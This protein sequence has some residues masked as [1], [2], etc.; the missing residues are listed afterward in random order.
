MLKQTRLEQI[1]KL[2]NSNGSVE[3]NQLCRLFGVT[4]M[5]ARRDLDELAKAGRVIRTHGGAVLSE[6]NIL[7]EKPF[8][9]RICSNYEQKDAIARKALSIIE[10]GSKLFFNSSSTV[11]CLASHI[12]NT[13]RLIVATEA[14]NI[15]NELNTRSN[16]SVIQIGGE[17]RKNTISCIGYFAEEMLK[18]FR[19]DAAFIGI[20]SIDE[21]GKLYC[22]STYEM[23]IYKSVFA[24]SRKIVVLADS[25]KLGNQDFTCIGSLSDIDTLITDSGISENL[26]KKYG[27]M[28]VN[29]MV[30][31]VPQPPDKL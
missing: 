29:L 12:D 11:F 10:D 18:H 31:E 27:E 7:V 15:A 26:L 23:G 2:L 19:F 25:T 8:E 20:N 16:V 5:T 22:G 24:C 17:L 6:D 30:A 13:R 4:E 14:I 28:D 3:I 21:D 1:I 9:A